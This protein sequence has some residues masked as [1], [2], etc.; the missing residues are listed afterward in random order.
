MTLRGLSW[1]RGHGGAA[2]LDAFVDALHASFHPPSRVCPLRDDFAPAGDLVA[3]HDCFD[4]GDIAGLAGDHAS[5]PDTLRARWLDGAANERVNTFAGYLD[6]N[7]EASA[8]DEA[9]T[10]CHDERR[11]ADASRLFAALRDLPS[12]TV[13]LLSADRAYLCL[14]AHNAHHFRLVRLDPI[15]EA[16]EPLPNA[17]SAYA[18]YHLQAIAAAVQADRA[19]GD[20]RARR[21]ADA[22]LLELYSHHFLEDALA[23]GHVATDRL[24]LNVGSAQRTHAWHNRAGVRMSATEPLRARADEVLDTGWRTSRD[25]RSLYLGDGQLSSA[26]DGRRCDGDDQ[27]RCRTLAAGAALVSMSL[28]EFLAAPGTDLGARLAQC[29]AAGAGHACGSP[30]FIQSTIDAG[31]LTAVRAAPR[32]VEW[33][34]SLT[35]PTVGTLTRMR[36]LAGVG[37]QPGADRVA[38][39]GEFS[40]WGEFLLSPFAQNDALP[41]LYV[42]LGAHLR[43]EWPAAQGGF[44]RPLGARVE[45]GLSTT[46]GRLGLGV[47]G[48]L[49]AFGASWDAVRPAL[50]LELDAGIR[51]DTG[52]ELAWLVDVVP[53]ASV[54]RFD[55]ETRWTLGLTVGVS[56][57]RPTRRAM[58]CSFARRPGRAAPEISTCSVDGE[59][60]YIR[61]RP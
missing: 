12:L 27:A 3:R 41:Q 22:L 61:L 4:L 30:R 13:A 18:F 10:V 9:P 14:A 26:L 23:G 5:T 53:G 44:A 15:A 35:A 50:S 59:S 48:E 17:F 36:G 7:W 51:A 47:G 25:E 49:A 55:G 38:P 29:D 54:A 57:E 24:A 11:A 21:M 45:V 16:S 43:P 8:G 52:D 32:A 46:F 6:G 40:L 56:F 42:G 1:V 58:P 28:E 2:R 39:T 37:W 60:E 31:H 20:A 33:T 34:R 19:T